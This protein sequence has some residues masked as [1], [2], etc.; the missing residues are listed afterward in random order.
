MQ[1]QT[2]RH[3]RAPGAG[4][5]KQ[6]N[7]ALDDVS[8]NYSKVLGVIKHDGITTALFVRFECPKQTKINCIYNTI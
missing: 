3:Y 8:P 7:I 5:A 6:S 4:K 1:I 2:K